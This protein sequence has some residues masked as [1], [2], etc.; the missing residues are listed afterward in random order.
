[1]ARGL[2]G[3][4]AETATT[5]AHN[6]M[7]ADEHT[8]ASS[9]HK[10]HVATEHQ[11]QR[12]NGQSIVMW[13]SH[14]WANISEVAN[15]SGTSFRMLVWSQ[16]EDLS[17]QRTTY[18]QDGLLLGAWLDATDLVT[19]QFMMSSHRRTDVTGE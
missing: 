6:A 8:T 16:I 4:R 7:S 10:C 18:Q 12:T 13:L 17:Q 11:Q 1:M 2:T 19:K 9:M 5:S 3:D 14:R 15:T